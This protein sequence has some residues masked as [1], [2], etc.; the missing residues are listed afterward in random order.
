MTKNEAAIISAYTGFTL[1]KFSD[2]HEYVE[3]VM[4]RPVWTHEMGDANFCGLL[5][6][7]SKP[8]FLAICEN[9]TD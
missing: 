7:K 1:C 8:D 6:E 3:K 5:K 2:I 9:L 4:Q